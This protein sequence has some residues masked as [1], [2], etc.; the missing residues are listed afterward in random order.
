MFKK[1]KSLIEKLVYRQKFD[2]KCIDKCV[3][4]NENAVVVVEEKYGHSM[5]HEKLVGGKL[6]EDKRWHLDDYYFYSIHYIQDNNFLKILVKHQKAE[7]KYILDKENAIIVIK[8]GNGYAMIHERLIDDNLVEINRWPLD[9]YYYSYRS[10]ERDKAHIWSLDLFKIQSGR[11]TYN[12][13]YDYKNDKFV[14]PPKIWD[15]IRVGKDDL[16]LKKYNGILAS[17]NISSDK[18]KD[19]VFTYENEITGEKIEE[20]FKV[21]DGY[22]YAIINLDG[23]IRGNKLFKGSTFPKITE[24]IDLDKYESLDAFKEERKKICNDTKKKQ[25][26]EYYQMIE[27]RND[28]NISPYLDSEVARIFN[29]KK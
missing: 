8:D 22:Y 25:K 16:Y 13:L 6:V 5:I 14:I 9:N 17:F 10:D 19:D 2:K 21:N 29:L 27:E 7:D 11:G 26:Q 4:D 12:A 24:I 18:E 28:G 1:R 15:R 20:S 3:L 23:T